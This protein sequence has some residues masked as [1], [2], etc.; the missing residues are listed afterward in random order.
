M[1]IGKEWDSIDRDSPGEGSWQARQH[2]LHPGPAAYRVDVR[3]T[4]HM[5]SFG[6]T[7]PFLAV[8][9]EV[10]PDLDAD[11]SLTRHE[12][13]LC[14][15]VTPWPVV[16]DVTGRYAVAFLKTHLAGESGYERWLAPGWA[17][18]ND[19][20]AELFTRERVSAAAIGSE[21]PADDTYYRHQSDVP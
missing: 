3:D 8:L 13:A 10:A 1:G 16:R 6:E 20:H 9:R 7:C 5:G 11:G 14:T 21:W 2:A 18:A 12:A 15:S 17:A 4:N 19:C